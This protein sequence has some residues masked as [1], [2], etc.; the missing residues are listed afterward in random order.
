MFHKKSENPASRSQPNIWT[1]Q[2]GTFILKKPTKQ[3]IIENSLKGSISIH[4]GTAQASKVCEKK[5]S[6]ITWQLKEFIISPRKLGEMIQYLTWAFFQMGWN[7]T[8][9]QKIWFH[10]IPIPQNGPGVELVWCW[11]PV[12]LLL[13]R[14]SQQKVDASLKLL[15]LSQ[16]VRKVL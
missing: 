6:W 4:L 16:V 2:Q 10:G 11:W 8:T 3:Q 12:T 1:V 14:W 13:K 5:W 9:N 7:S 15:I